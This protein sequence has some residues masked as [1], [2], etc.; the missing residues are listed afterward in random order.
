MLK[1]L[2]FIRNEPRWS[3][4]NDKIGKTSFNLRVRVRYRITQMFFFF[5]FLY[6]VTEMEILSWEFSKK[7]FLISY[8]KAILSHLASFRV[9][10]GPER[11]IMKSGG[12]SIDF[13]LIIF[14]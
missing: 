10:D 9:D 13:Y 8:D 7:K 1:K 5:F 3:T 6:L 12:C 11:P 4:F 2:G 14:G